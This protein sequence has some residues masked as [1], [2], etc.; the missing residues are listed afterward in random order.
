[1]IFYMYKKLVYILFIFLTTS[2]IINVFYRPFIASN[3]IFDFGI[4]DIGNNFFFIPIAYLSIFLIR[5]S[6]IFGKNKDILFHLIFLTFYEFL[7]FFFKIFG[8]FDIKDILGLFIGAFLTKFI[9]N[10]FIAENFN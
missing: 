6:F 8:V 7:S 1:M 3:K 2:I 9:S 4:S 5:K 10:A